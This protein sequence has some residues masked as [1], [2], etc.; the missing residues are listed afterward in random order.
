MTY[1]YR[2]ERNNSYMPDASSIGGPELDTILNFGRLTSALLWDRRNDPLNATSGTFTA[3]SWD[4]G[5]KWL[6]SDAR[7]G[8]VLGQQHAFWPFGATVLAS[9]VIA[10]TTFGGDVPLRSDRFLAGGA[11]TVR[12][13]AENALGPREFGLP[14]GGSGMLLLNQEVRFP[15]YRWMRGVGFVDAGNVYGAGERFGSTALKVGYG[16]G[17]R[18]DSPVGLLR[19]DFGVPTSSLDSRSGG[20]SSGRWYFGFG[21]IF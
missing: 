10:G 12:G 7:Y 15:V 16:F 18:F 17:L 9:R 6:R 5:A 13:Y 19:L 2:F 3:V 11:T 8:K 4:Q 1:G 14:L 20:F 21:N